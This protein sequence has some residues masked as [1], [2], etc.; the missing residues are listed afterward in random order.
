M[1][2]AIKMVPGKSDAEIA[3]ELADRMSAVLAPVC[4]IMDE[5]RKQGFEIN[6]HLAPD[7]TGRTVVANNGPVI[8][9]RFV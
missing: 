2:E 1:S 6:F 4:A 8:S 7:W 9:K 3:R 5:A